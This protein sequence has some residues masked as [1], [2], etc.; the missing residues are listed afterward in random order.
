MKR[1]TAIMII[2]LGCYLGLVSCSDFL[3]V[4]PQDKFLQSQV[5]S[6]KQ[7]FYNALNGIY[8]DISQ[9]NL[10]GRNLSMGVLDVMAQLYDLSDGRNSYHFFSDY[11]Y[12]YEYAMDTFNSIWTAAY[13]SIL[14]CNKFL[15]SIQNTD[16]IPDEKLDILR[17]EAIGVRAML[18]FDMLRLFGPVYSENPT[19]KAIPYYKKV[20]IN[21]NDI[22][23]A[24][25][26]IKKVLADLKIAEKLLQNDPIITNGVMASLTSTPK[27]FYRYRN[28]RM[29]Y[30]AVKALQARVNLYAGNNKAALDAATTVIDHAQKWF[31]W[32]K[33]SDIL[34][35]GG[36]PDRVFSAE[37]IFGIHNNSMYDI[38]KSLFSSSLS[39]INILQPRDD[40]LKAIYENNQ[41]DYRYNPWWKIASAGHNNSRAFIKYKDVTDKD[42]SWRYFQSLIRMSEMYYIAAE[43]TPDKAQAID[44][45]DTVRYHR[46]LQDLPDNADITEEIEKA[47]KKEFYGEGQLFFYYKRKNV[48]YIPSGSSPYDI[49]LGSK[50]YVVPLPNS[51]TKLRSQNN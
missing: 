4:Q 35:A 33:Q 1:L 47:Y 6:S 21:A 23:P 9:P 36:N 11:A 19:G 12:D 22:L 8:I 42:S 2:S 16:L 38:Q 39:F 28:R 17:G 41:N 32:V 15:S 46:G 40:N 51:E 27:D 20:Q 49:A 30:Y 7:G 50:E 25:Q 13:S 45:L 48:P 18:H 31:P 10:Y 34:A 3:N 5:Y 44:Y 43:T 24:D 29:N 26:V 14:D 37:I